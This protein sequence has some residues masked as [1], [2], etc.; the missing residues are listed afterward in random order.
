MPSHRLIERVGFGLLVAL[1]IFSTTVRA[2]P[3]GCSTADF[4]LARTFD[5]STNSGFPVSAYAVADFNGDGKP[6]IA[7]TDSGAGTVV[8][9][10][11]DGS[12]RPIVSRTY[13]T[14]VAPRSVAAVDLNGDGRPDLIVTNSQSNNV[15]I[16]LNLGG[17]VFSAAVNFPVAISPAEIAVGD[18]NADGKPDLAIAAN[19]NNA[20]GRLS[21]LLGDGSGSFIQ[22]PNS[23]ITIAG[24]AHGVAVGDFNSDGKRDVIVATL[25]N[26]YFELLGDGT[27]R[28]ASPMQV[29]NVSGFAVATADLNGDGKSDLAIGTFIGLGILLGN[30]SGGF[31]APVFTAQEGRSR[32][33]AVAIADIDGDGKLDVAA[34]TDDPGGVT[35]FKGDGAGGVIVTPSYLPSKTGGT[36]ALGDFDGDGDLDVVSGESILTN[37]GGGVFEAARA[38]YP[39]IG[40]NTLTPSYLALGDFNGDGQTDMAV[41]LVPLTSPLT[42]G[43]SILLKDASGNFTRGPAISFFGG[44]TLSGIVAADFN[45]DGKMDLAVP[46]SVSSPFSFVVAIYLGNGDGTFAAPTNINIGTQMMDIAT[47]D[48][49]NDGNPDLVVTGL[50]GAVVALLGNGS[51]GFSVR[52]APTVGSFAEVA[53]ADL[54]NDGKADLIITDFSRQQ[55]W[56]EMGDGTGSFSNPRSF[57]V[58]GTP[59]AVAL[60]D[61]NNDGKMDVSVANQPA[62]TQGGQS[63]ISVLLGD[64]AGSLGAAVNYPAGN[65]P[66]AISVGDLDGDGK[67]D[68]AV[69]NTSSS[70]IAI[71]SG[72]GSGEF[73]NP[74]SFNIWGEPVDLLISDLDGDGRPDIATGLRSSRTVGLMFGKPAIAQPCL[75][76][77]DVTV[78]EG[79]SG[80]STAQ[81]PVRLSQASAQTVTVAYV[82]KQGTAID[83]QDYVGGGGAVTFQPGEVSKTIP[84]PIIGD[85][86]DENDETFTVNLSGAV[87]ANISDG[88]ATVTIADNDPPPSISIND[89]SIAEGNTCCGFTFATFTVSLSAPSAKVIGVDFATANGTAIAG[90]DYD[91]AQGHLTFGSFVTTQTMTVG[92]RGDLTHE[93]DETF[94]VNLTNANNATIGK[95]QGQGTILN[96]DPLPA[97]TIFDASASE[98]LGADTTM[99]VTVRL[100]NASSDPVSIAYS[101]ADGTA[102]GGGVDYAGT[103]GTLTFNPGETQKTISVTIKDDTIDEINETF[104][105]NLSTPTNATISD[106][107]ALCTIIDNDGPTISINDVSVTEGTGGTNGATFTLTLSAASPQL[108]AVVASTAD[109]TAINGSDYGRVTN[110]GILFQPG[111]TTA[112]LTVSIVPDA[113][114]EQNETF[115]INLS[116]PSNATI[117]D[118]QGV[119]TIIDDD[120]TSAQMSTDAVSVNESDGSV[121]LTVQH[122]GDVSK[123]FTVNYSTFDISATQTS[124]YTAALGQ[125]KFAAGETSRTVAIFITDDSLTEGAEIFGFSISGPN[126]ARL[127]APSST[128]VTI[129]A[130]DL[131]PGPNPI[132]ATSFFVKQH[133]RDF[134]NRDP[135]QSGLDFWTGQINSCGGDTACAEVK[136]INVS[137]AFFLSIEFQQTGYLV[138]RM[139]KTAYGDASGTSALGGTPHQLAV[140][141]VRYFE[142]LQDT[143]RIG[144]GVVVLAPGWE[145]ALENNKQAYASEFAQTSR[146]ITAFPT[147]MTPAQFIDRLN[148]NAGNVLSASERTAAVNLFGS[149]G[150]TS[151]MTARAQALRQVAEDQDLYTAENNRAFVL[152]QYFGY[153]RRNPNDSPEP[154]LDY[155]GY[156]FWLTKLNQFNGDNIAAEM[157]KAFISSSE[158]RQRFGP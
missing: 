116:A 21:I 99:A 74:I 16:L 10:F 90:D 148:Q 158:Y 121:R 153:L 102:T 119:C 92:I 59:A 77:D 152:A 114:I 43:I 42:G 14:G 113:V 15:S 156:D 101:F 62:P 55:V 28:F 67:L 94:F 88:V 93:P 118:G 2:A 8:V 142:F 131:T 45:K 71:Y 115:F 56:T 126:G 147:T 128:F 81:V 85:T 108:I 125:I 111:A 4:K 91:A 105:I 50:H 35:Y 33:T 46:L 5:A 41:G 87:N 106:G 29:S 89:V 155:T 141:I 3:D 112:T 97:I 157:V 1:V 19:G 104:F 63:S 26:G 84:V 140:P 11:N 83:G 150:D 17:G 47:G 129:N 139:Y 122:I 75:F 20:D 7:E 134:L 86:T 132:D 145:Q 146:F 73:R 22:A 66:S 53:T 60:G 12:G 151:N 133:Y 109:G 39:L 18:F 130:N 54:N 32:I 107:Q 137:A 68:L 79:D 149:A 51:G 27:G 76:I 36:F 100:S 38:A 138:E 48:F 31:S 135:D 13:P 72:D 25:T 61:F 120:V 110:R 124:D 80:N 69:A 127:G 117:A 64:G 144:Q 49:N 40:S 98:G 95:S 143:Q 78:T 65:M 30:G 154:T 136:R 9:M 24:E 103:P 96:D 52:S 44:T 37:I 23:P 58:G 57:T 34:A 6:D 123:P 82:T 70:T